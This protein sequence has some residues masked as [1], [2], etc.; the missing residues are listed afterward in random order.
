LTARSGAVGGRVCMQPW[1]GAGVASLADGTYNLHQMH[2]ALPPA[3]LQ[4]PWVPCMWCEG[5]RIEAPMRFG[6]AQHGQREWVGMRLY[7]VK[8]HTNQACHLGRCR[9]AA[10]RRQAAK[11]LRCRRAAHC[12]QSAKALRVW[13]GWRHQP[14]AVAPWR[15]A[16]PGKAAPPG[17]PVGPRGTAWCLIIEGW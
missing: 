8:A 15:A 12:R 16:W 17:I 5:N 3:P 4:H 14:T 7:V 6:P 2:A 1:G 10:R 9:R 11:A 13:G